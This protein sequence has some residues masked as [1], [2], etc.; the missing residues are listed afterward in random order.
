MPS[1]QRV[2][3]SFENNTGSSEMA[4]I[5]AENNFLLLNEETVYSM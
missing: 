4:Y 2:P 1:F 3:V 5:V